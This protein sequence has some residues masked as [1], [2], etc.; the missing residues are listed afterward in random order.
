MTAEEALAP[1]LARLRS[2]HDVL[3]FLERHI[4]AGGAEFRSM[5]EEMVELIASSEDFL[6]PPR[7]GGPV[8]IQFE[9]EGT[10]RVELI[11]ARPSFDG[12]LWVIA[13]QGR[14]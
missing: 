5:P 10:R 3:P 1:I 8:W 12:E 2:T 11:I 14:T 7:C 13:P 9:S 6:P 4:P